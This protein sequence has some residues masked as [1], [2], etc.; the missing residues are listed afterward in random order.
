MKTFFFLAVFVP[1]IPVAQAAED[2]T[3]LRPPQ[4]CT[5]QYAPVCGEKAGVHQNYPNACFAAADK[6]R[7]V[8]DGECLSKR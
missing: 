3:N 4:V 2:P 5:Q 8:A 7:V 6:A 1:L